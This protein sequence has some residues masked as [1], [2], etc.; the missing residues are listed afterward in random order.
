MRRTTTLL[1][2]T[3]FKKS[4]GDPETAAGGGGGGELSTGGAGGGGKSIVRIVV[5]AAED[6]VEVEARCA[7]ARRAWVRHLPCGSR[8]FGT[9][10][11]G[12]PRVEDYAY[13]CDSQPSL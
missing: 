9:K 4:V 5:V 7:F 11:I 10:W 8:S 2:T 13:K 12:S 6:C 3:P 1:P